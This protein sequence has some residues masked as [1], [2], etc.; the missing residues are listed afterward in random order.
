MTDGRGGTPE[1]ATIDAST[2]AGLLAD[3]D[4]RR[5]LA[6]VELGAGTLEATTTATG[7]PEH[8]VAKAI[9]KL[10][11][12]GLLTSSGGVLAVDGE[13]IAG[14]ARRARQ[15]PPRT[16]HAAELPAIRKVLDAFVHDG[17]LTAIP[18]APSKR[19]TVFDWLARR[20][21]PGRRY[22]E[23][24]VTAMLDGHAEDAVTLRR[25]L[26]DAGFLDRRDGVYWR[27]G[28]TVELSPQPPDA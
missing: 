7:L 22:R 15:R 24:E 6:A 17:Q 5:V 19:R 14:A 25:Y 10:V 2:I 18:A 21:E 1:R 28:G 26:V 20:F 27:S 23:A 9:G 12:A 11:D 16:E 4:R 8:R 3:A 13:A